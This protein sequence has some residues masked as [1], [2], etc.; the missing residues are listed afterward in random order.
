MGVNRKIRTVHWLFKCS[1]LG[2]TSRI[3]IIA[4]IAAG[5]LMHGV[6]HACIWDAETLRTERSRHPKM[7]EMVLGKTSHTENTAELRKRIRDLRAAPRE[8]DAAWWNNLAG[9]HI[10][11]GEL[12]TA[13]RRR[14]PLTARFASDFGSP[15]CLSNADHPVRR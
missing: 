10:R 7:A 4:V 2:V 12:E 9:A 6:V 15:E 3:R 5:I 14:E 8:E 1:F 13:V 11:L